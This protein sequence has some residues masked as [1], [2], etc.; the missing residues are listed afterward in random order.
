M[1]IFRVSGRSKTRVVGLNVCIA[2]SDGIRHWYYVYG[3]LRRNAFYDKLGFMTLP[4]LRLMI[5]FIIVK[6]A[7]YTVP[8]L[9][10]YPSIIRKQKK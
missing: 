6:K 9:L 4:N 5:G 1:F 2:G 3:S 8:T 7:I 10:G